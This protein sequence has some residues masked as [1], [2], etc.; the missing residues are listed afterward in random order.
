MTDMMMEGSVDGRKKK[1]KG[2]FKGVDRRW[3]MV[4]EEDGEEAVGVVVVEGERAC[5]IASNPT[6]GC[7]DEAE[8]GGTGKGR[9][10]RGRAQHAQSQTNAIPPASPVPKHFPS[11]RWSNQSAPLA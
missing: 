8:T 11:P 10:R 7:D 2:M 9:G 3:R 4:E 5:L 1:A 6:G